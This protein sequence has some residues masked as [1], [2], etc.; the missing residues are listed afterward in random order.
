VGEGEGLAEEVWKDVGGLRSYGRTGFTQAASPRLGSLTILQF[1]V[2]WLNC[3]ATF[4]KISR[5]T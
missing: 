1:E 3:T 4:E 2:V 5:A